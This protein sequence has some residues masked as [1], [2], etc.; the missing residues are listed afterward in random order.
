MSPYL[1]DRKVVADF[2][3]DFE[4]G[5]M[6]FAPWLATRYS[7]ARSR[8]QVGAHLKSQRVFEASLTDQS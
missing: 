8:G 2:E 3:L 7:R 5:G 1:T 4:C 6:R